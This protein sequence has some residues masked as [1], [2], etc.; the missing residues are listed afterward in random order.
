MT[1][2]YGVFAHY[3][4]LLRQPPPSSNMGLP[5]TQKAAVKVGEGESAKVEI[6]EIPVPSPGPGQILVRINYS[7]LCASDKSLLHDEWAA[8]GLAML[9]ETQGIAGHEGAGVVAAVADD[10]KDLW[11]EGDRAGVKWIASV[12]GKCEFCTNGRDECH[13]PSQKNS[14]FSVAGTFQEY[15]KPS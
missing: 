13:C 9:P 3:E 14:G 11:K 6:R 15:C 10:V 4:R 2:R 5:S 8:G 12:C 1:S 7:G